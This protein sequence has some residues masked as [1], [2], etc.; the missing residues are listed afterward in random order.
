M[1]IFNYC[2]TGFTYFFSYIRTFLNLKGLNVLAIMS[3]STAAMLMFC[4][5]PICFAGIDTLQIAVIGPMSGKDHE[6]GQAMLDGV[7]LYVDEVNK[8]GG[9]NGRKLEVIAYDDQND[10][11]MAKIRPWKLPKTATP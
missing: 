11:V 1:R 5:V 9:I 3:G 6:G 10:K 7:N 2:H 4:L 8:N